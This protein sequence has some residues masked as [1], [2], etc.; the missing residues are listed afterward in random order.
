VPRTPTTGFEVTHVGADI[1]AE[2]TAFG[3]AC[4]LRQERR[5]RPLHFYEL[6]LILRLL[7]YRK[8]PPLRL[9]I[10]ADKMEFAD[11][12]KAKIAEV[13]RPLHFSEILRIANGLGY[14]K[15]GKKSEVSNSPRECTNA[16]RA[17]ASPRRRD[18]RP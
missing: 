13:E 3:H 14:R 18:R 1:T 9:P 5:G 17:K 11:A 7:G 8:P 16:A 4:R 15:L 2:Q 6:L 12:M 10:L